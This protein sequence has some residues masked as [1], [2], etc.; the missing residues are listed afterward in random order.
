MS[1]C[2]V[3]VSFLMEYS[4]SSKYVYMLQQREYSCLVLTTLYRSEV[5]LKGCRLDL[6]CRVIVPPV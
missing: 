2:T 6:L 4:T 3:K 1:V 5:C